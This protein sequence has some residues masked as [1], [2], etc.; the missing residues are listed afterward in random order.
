M[1]WLEIDS[2][3][4][5]TS[6]TYDAYGNKTSVTDANG[7]T[8]NVMGKCNGDGSGIINGVRSN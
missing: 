6:Y 1:K 8:T 4:N 7:K 2:L 5:E 3:G